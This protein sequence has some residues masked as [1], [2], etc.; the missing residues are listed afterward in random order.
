MTDDQLV[1]NFIEHLAQLESNDVR[2]TISL[3]WR[4]FG[5]IVFIVLLGITLTILAL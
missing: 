5:K 2:D 1:D 3:H 4:L